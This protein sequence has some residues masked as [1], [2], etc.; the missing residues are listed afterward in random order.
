MRVGAVAIHSHRRV[1]VVA[2]LKNIVLSLLLQQA[3]IA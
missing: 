2:F 1:G 3:K